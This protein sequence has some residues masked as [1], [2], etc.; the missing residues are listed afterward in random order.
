MLSKKFI[1]LQNKFSYS[2]NAISGCEQL[3]KDYRRVVLLDAKLNR[4]LG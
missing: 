3:T 1:G 2:G 4:Q